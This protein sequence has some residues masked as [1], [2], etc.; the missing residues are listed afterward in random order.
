MW[1][2][3][4]SLPV[5][6]ND[7]WFP[8]ASSKI[9]MTNFVTTR[10]VSY[11]IISPTPLGP[12]ATSP[13]RTPR[14]PQNQILLRIR[15]LQKIRLC[16]PTFRW[17]HIGELPRRRYHLCKPPHA[18]PQ[19]PPLKPKAPTHNSDRVLRAR[20]LSLFQEIQLFVRPIGLSTGD[21][22]GGVSGCQ[23]RTPPTRHFRQTVSRVL[24]YEAL[25]RGIQVSEVHTAQAEGGG[26]IRDG[27]GERE[28]FVDV[29]V[30]PM[31]IYVKQLQL[32]KKEADVAEWVQVVKARPWRISPWFFCIPSIWRLVSTW[33]FYSLGMRLSWRVRG[34]G[35]RLGRM[36]MWSVRW[37]SI[38]L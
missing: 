4:S 3:R 30:L 36:G 33:R 25:P 11:S 38:S 1:T 26:I 2:Q 19:P 10:R 13:L 7:Q 32:R 27:L 24:V 21:G 28:R 31:G 6:I 16:Q 20:R 14:H 17:R 23:L 12:L 34:R 9:V 37:G 15:L 35:W 29:G 8:T 5:L 22:F 18:P